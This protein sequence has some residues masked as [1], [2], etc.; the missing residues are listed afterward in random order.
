MLDAEEQVDKEGGWI[1]KATQN[2]IFVQL[3]SGLTLESKLVMGL[4]HQKLS[5]FSAIWLVLFYLFLSYFESN[6]LIFCSV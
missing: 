4:C 5:D 2:I 3:T 6:V 1:G